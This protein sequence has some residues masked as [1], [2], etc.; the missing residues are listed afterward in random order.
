MKQEVIL[1]LDCGATNVRAIAVNR[2]GKIVARASTPNAS[3]IAMENNTWHQWSLDAILQRFADCCRQINSELTECHIRGIA[4]TT[5][6][7]DGALVDKQGNLLYPII[8]W[9]CPRTAAVMDNIERL[10]SAQR[11]QA[12]S[13]VG[14]FSFNTLYKLVWLKENHPQLLERAHAWLFISSLINHRLTGEFTTD[15]TMA[16]TS[17]MLDIQQRDF[18]PQILQATGIPRRLFPRL[19]EAGEQIG[20]LQNSAAAMLGLSVGIPVISAGHDTQFALF[21][22]GAEQNEPVL[23]SGTWEILMV[24]SAQ[25]DTSLLSQYAGSTCELDSQAGLY[26]PGMQWLASGVLEWVRKLFWTAETPWQMLIEEARLI[27]PGADGV[28]MQCDLL[29]CQNAG[30]QGVT[31]NTTRGH[32]YRAAL[33]GLTA[34][35]QR[36]LQMLEKIGHFKASELL[37][38]GGGSRN[39]LWNQIKANML[40][41]PVKVLDDAETTVAGAALFGWYGVGEFNSPEEARAQIHYQYRYFYPQ[42]EPEFIEEV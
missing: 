1:V 28:K 5:F 30:W 32:F 39:T 26:N 14:A 20:T 23:S 12:I 29:S 6:G 3:D 8:S 31:L 41:I 27:A 38:V 17:Q 15:I 36:N 33:E 10:I 13:G 37:L 7:V 34:Q 22:A 42:T 40:D 21:G 19:V 9:K 18:S 2:Q 4:V 25:V 16:G 11:L 35:L 24:R